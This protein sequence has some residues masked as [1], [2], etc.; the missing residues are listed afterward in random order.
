[1]STGSRCPTGQ[2]LYTIQTDDNKRVKTLFSELSQH[3]PIFTDDRVGR[4]MT[5]EKNTKPH[6]QP[7]HR[8]SLPQPP[9][10][11][12]S[13]YPFYQ[14]RDAIASVLP[15]DR[16]HSL[17]VGEDLSHPNKW[18]VKTMPPTGIPGI[19]RLRT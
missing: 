14:N 7:I 10:A 3:K 4:H 16:K 11:D 2:G 18:G 6:S 15:D 13:G 5:L 8:M 12:P 19:E 17:T 1:M 9:T